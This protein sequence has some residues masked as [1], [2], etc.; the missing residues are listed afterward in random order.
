VSALDVIG[1]SPIF[2]TYDGGNLTGEKQLCVML[3]YELVA[4]P[5][6]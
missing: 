3:C 1:L 4:P 6:D 5:C 2:V